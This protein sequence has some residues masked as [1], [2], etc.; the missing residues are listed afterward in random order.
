MSTGDKLDVSGNDLLR[1]WADDD[2]TNVVLLQLE[3]FGDPSASPGWPTPCHT[4]SRWSPC[5][6]AQTATG[7]RIVAVPP[8]Q[9]IGSS[10][11]CSPTPASSGRDTME[12][13]IDVGLLLDRQAAPAGCASP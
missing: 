2:T 10:M 1:L 11:R 8:P 7:R 12:E 9:P 6:A 5:K 13:L 3:S 4:A